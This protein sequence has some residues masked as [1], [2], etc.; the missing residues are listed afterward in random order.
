MHCEHCG[1]EFIPSHFNQ[2]FCCVRCQKDHRRQSDR[3]RKFGTDKRVNTKC[4]VCGCDIPDNRKINAITCSSECLEKY[5]ENI[6]KYNKKE[7][8][9][10]QSDR[11]LNHEKYMLKGARD[12]ANKRG[13]EFSLDIG[14]LE[15]PDVCP[16]LGI[17]MKKVEYGKTKRGFNGESY[18]I[19]RL[20]PT[21]GYT[22]EN[23]RVISMRAN[24]LKMDA[25]TE[26]VALLLDYM[27]NNNCP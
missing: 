2:R 9:R 19:D 17:P 12:R 20:D 4:I 7:R 5:M 24:R 13:L 16:V 26:E 10:R 21:K 3:L 25:S 15:I 27:R 14:D 11:G 22:K 8:L 23:C 18:S 6:Y 1:V